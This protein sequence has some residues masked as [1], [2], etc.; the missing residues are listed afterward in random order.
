M[1]GIVKQKMLCR[2]RKMILYYYNHLRF[3]P[4]T[5][6]DNL[7]VFGGYNKLYNGVDLISCYIG[8]GTYVGH[9]SKLSFAKIGKFCSIGQD[10]RIVVGHHPLTQEVSS[11]PAFYSTREQAGFTFARE[12][13]YDEFTYVD[14]E[15]R[16]CVIIGND[17]WIG[18]NAIILEGVKIGDGAAIGAGS[19][20][21]KDVEPF[22]VYVG[23]P[24]RMIKYR[25]EKQ[26]RDRILGIPGGIIRLNI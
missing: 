16:Y 14:T 10:V 13:R 24:Q 7:T 19:L 18:S 8:E 21:T 1:I 26:K 23:N 9:R 6:F 5:Y 17:V 20:I 15:N 22:S 12:S 25:F 2:V 11:H 3:E 4:G